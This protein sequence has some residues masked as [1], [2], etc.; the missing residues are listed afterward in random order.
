MALWA[1]GSARDMALWRYDP[2]RVNWRYCVTRYGVMTPKT[3]LRA[4]SSTHGERP[5]RRRCR[6]RP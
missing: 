4:R 1:C 6:T 3:I 5:N 2:V